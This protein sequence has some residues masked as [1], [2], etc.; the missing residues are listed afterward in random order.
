MIA[1]KKIVLN[2]MIDQAKAELPNECCG[3][4][5]GKDGVI[6]TQYTMFNIDQSPEHF[7]FDPKEQFEA[8]RNARSLGLKLVANYHSHPSTPSR[9]SVEDIKLA[10]DPTILYLIISLAAEVPVVKAFSIVDSNV[11]EVQ[12]NIID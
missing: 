4:L 3:Y 10:Y 6:T 1:I 2:N 8:M 9:P 5:G 7:S 12:L 11:E